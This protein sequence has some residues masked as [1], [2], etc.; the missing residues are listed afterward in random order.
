MARKALRAFWPCLRA[1][2]RM[3]A[4]MAEASAPQS[5]R[6]P[7]MTLRW[8]TEGRRSRSELLLVGSTSSRSRKTNRLPRWVQ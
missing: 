7:P 2:A 4:R 3:L 5:E 1:V 8:M 6:K